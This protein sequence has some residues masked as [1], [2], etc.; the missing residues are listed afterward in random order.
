LIWL[1]VA[2]G[3]HWIKTSSVYQTLLRWKEQARRQLRVF[4]ARIRRLMRRSEQ[5]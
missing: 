5:G 1:N 4:L 2:Y 3:K